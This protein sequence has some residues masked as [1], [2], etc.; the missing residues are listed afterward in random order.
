MVSTDAA[1][2]P[3]ARVID[4]PSSVLSLFAVGATPTTF[5]LHE[6]GMFLVVL[7]LSEHWTLQ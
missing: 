5:E 6:S 3:M 1:D 7:N 2:E 4:V